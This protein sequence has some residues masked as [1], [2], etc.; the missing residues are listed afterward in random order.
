VFPQT[1]SGGIL[2][3]VARASSPRFAKPDCRLMLNGR[4]GIRNVKLP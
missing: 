4:F 1:R 2:P 3:A